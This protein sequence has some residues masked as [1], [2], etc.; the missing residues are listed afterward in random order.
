MNEV[1]RKKYKYEIKS[2]KKSNEESCGFLKSIW[3]NDEKR[4]E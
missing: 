2:Y 3:D 4:T 1:L